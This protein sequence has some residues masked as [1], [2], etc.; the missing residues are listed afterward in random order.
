MVR[1]L[2]VTFVSRIVERGLTFVGVTIVLR[3]LSPA[4]GGGF[5]LLLKAS[6]LASALA[7]LGVPAAAVRFLSASFGR[8]D[9]KEAEAI[10]AAFLAGRMLLALALVA[11]GWVVSPFIAVSLH[12]PEL[13]PIVFLACVAA[14][15]NAVLAFP[16]AHL[17]ARGWFGRLAVLNAGTT[18]AKVV[19][20]VGLIGLGARSAKTI[21]AGWSLVPAAGA[22]IGVLLTPRGYLRFGIG[23]T[24][25]L[26]AVKALSKLS[27]WLAIGGAASLAAVNIDAL[28]LTRYSDLASV[29]EYGAATNLALAVTVVGGVFPTVLF[30]AVARTTRRAMLARYFASCFWIGGVLALLAMVVGLAAGAPVMHVLYGVRLGSAVP[31]FYA[32]YAAG[33]ISIV[34]TTAS[35]AFLALDRPSWIA[36]ASVVQLV[37]TAVVLVS[38]P[39]MS[40]TGA[41]LSVLAGQLAMAACVLGFGI[42]AFRK[43]RGDAELSA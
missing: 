1:S 41:G 19:V 28:L 8:G 10:L 43:P 36:V 32:L 20:V 26:G 37:I 27:G 31:A 29:G 38:L 9:E 40:T 30:P 4:E 22:A 6:A 7:S 13:A 21:S 15:T 39:H 16:L 42:L 14:A 23:A 12:H 35:L 3:H 33:L 11:L 18:I 5:A 34:S 17:Q 24:R 25:L 2:G